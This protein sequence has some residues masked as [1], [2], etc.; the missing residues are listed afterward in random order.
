MSK[1]NELWNAAKNDPG[2]AAKVLG[3][4]LLRPIGS[5]DYRK[6]I[7]LTKS[8]C[9]SNLLLS[10][11]NSHPNVYTE[12]EV[13]WKLKGRP[14]E[15]ILNK[16]FGKQPAYIKAK[17]FKI[18]YYHPL[19]HAD[20]GVWKDLAK[21][22]DLHVIHLQR[23]NILRGF[24]SRKIAEQN[25]AWM[26]THK[27]QNATK[28]VRF[29]A[30]ELQHL[31]EQTQQRVDDGDTLFENHPKISIYYENLVSDPKVYQSVLEFLDVPY[32]AP[33]SVL[34]RQNPEPLKA[35]LE[36]FEELKT[37]FADSRWSH[38]FDM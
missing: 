5:R 22:P 1:L 24:V 7:V 4:K 2:K 10:Y 34:K 31:F 17:G 12:G 6:F 14:Y 16:S 30:D 13:F 18:F 19:D 23:K 38:L 20:S 8:R 9:G 29:E 33:K 25:A 26:S 15:D 27:S 3:I 11:L 21:M 28:Q 35:L 32:V 37:A 36:N